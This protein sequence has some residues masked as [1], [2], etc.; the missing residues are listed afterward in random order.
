MCQAVVDVKHHWRQNGADN[1]ERGCSM[2]VESFCCLVS[3]AEACL[4]PLHQCAYPRQCLLRFYV[5][6]QHQVLQQ[7][8]CTSVLE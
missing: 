4:K 8:G 7:A 3:W 1:A 6:V 5:K 2:Q